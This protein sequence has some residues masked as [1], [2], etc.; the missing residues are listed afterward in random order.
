MLGRKQSMKGD[1]VLAD[2]G[3]GETLTQLGIS[4]DVDWRKEDMLLCAG[5]DPRSH[6]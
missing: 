2:Y 6:L 5:G 1:E 3:A 4:G